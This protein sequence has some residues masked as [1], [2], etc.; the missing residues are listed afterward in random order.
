MFL[1]N[2]Q[3]SFTLIELLV[4]I[5]I[6]GILAG[7]IIVSVSSSISKASIA[8]LKVSENNIQSELGANMVSR[9]KLDETI[10]TT[11]P[12]AWGI[13]TGNLI[14]GPTLKDENECVSGNCLAFNGTNYIS[15]GD[16]SSYIGKNNITFSIWVKPLV[17]GVDGAST[18][19]FRAF[20][21]KG[22][23]G[24]SGDLHVGYRADNR[25]RV[26]YEN[27]STGSYID[28]VDPI[29]L[30]EWSYVVVSTDSSKISLYIDGKFITSKSLA[31][32]F[33]INNMQ[34]GYCPHATYFNGLI[35]DVRIYNGALSSAQIKQQYVSG[36]D[37]L[38]SKG[39]ISES[40]FND[41]ISGK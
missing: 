6:I 19:T 35:D 11:T 8:K 1:M 38:Y 26:Y 4:V 22:G 23:A 27:L 9:W 14:N 30:N 12:D 3:K 17:S 28:S 34:I 31:T 18:Y 40:E 7:V 16:L 32:N 37:S 36:L 33:V 15:C 2:K 5:V 25:V 20:M 10:G 21:G 13:N 24:A 41:R 29:S 39:I